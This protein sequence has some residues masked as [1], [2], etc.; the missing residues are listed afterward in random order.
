VVHTNAP[1][2]CI[3]APNSKQLWGQNWH[4]LAEGKQLC[5]FLVA[6]EADP[7]KYREVHRQIGEL[8]NQYSDRVISKSIDEY[9]PLSSWDLA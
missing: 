7:P 6:R 4:E 3:L 2:G 1:Y 5:P 8:L 9:C